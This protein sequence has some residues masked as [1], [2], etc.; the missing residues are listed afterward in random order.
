MKLVLFIIS[1]L[2]FSCSNENVL[3]QLAIKDIPEVEYNRDL[4]GKIRRLGYQIKKVNED[5][6]KE[7]MLMS[8]RDT[9]DKRMNEIRNDYIELIDFID[10]NE[11][12]EFEKQVMIRYQGILL[13]LETVKTNYPID[14]SYESVGANL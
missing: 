9:F 13:E 3:E 14:K 1:F 2:L 8:R 7:K 11:S 12:K 5:K 6:T 4:E 10:K